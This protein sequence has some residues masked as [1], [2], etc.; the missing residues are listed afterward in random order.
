MRR[1]RTT[2]CL[3]VGE[4]R[5]LDQPSTWW[6]T[7]KV[8]CLAPDLWD[9]WQ[10]MCRMKTIFFV[11]HAVHARGSAW[12]SSKR[13]VV[14]QLFSGCKRT[15]EMQ[16]T[17]CLLQKKASNKTP[18]PKPNKNQHKPPRK[19]EGIQWTKWNRKTT[20]SKQIEPSE[21]SE[22]LRDDIVKFRK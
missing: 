18:K 10:S 7:W 19:E 4:R 2:A 17:R 11:A 21:H 15:G 8:V 5:Q 12:R 22:P 3:L 6:N 1:R 16:K 20:L 13:L 14:G 9:A